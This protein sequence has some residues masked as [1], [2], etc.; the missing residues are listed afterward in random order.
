MLPADGSEREHWLV[1][2]MDQYGAHITPQVLRLFKD[3][4]IHVV[5]FP[6]H[7]SELL[8]PLDLVVNSALKKALEVVWAMAKGLQPRFLTSRFTPRD[9]LEL[10]CTPQVVEVSNIL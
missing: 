2:L 8:Q 3:N 1:L 4:K 6:P 5:G 7:S 10:I 9:W